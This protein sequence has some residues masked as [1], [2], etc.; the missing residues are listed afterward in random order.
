MG[1]NE[2]QCDMEN[3]ALQFKMLPNAVHGTSVNRQH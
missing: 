2:L 3:P 1:A